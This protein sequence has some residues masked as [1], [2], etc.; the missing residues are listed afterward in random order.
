MIAE[1]GQHTLKTEKQA[2][3]LL[4]RCEL[5]RTWTLLVLARVAYRDAAFDAPVCDGWF[6]FPQKK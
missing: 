3:D 2:C 5:W 6:S 4:W 1:T